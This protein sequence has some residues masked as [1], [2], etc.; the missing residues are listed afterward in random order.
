[1]A[2]K[3]GKTVTAQPKK[4]I[5]PKVEKTAGK[6]SNTEKKAVKEVEGKTSFFSTFLKKKT[7]S[8]YRQKEEKDLNGVEWGVNDLAAERRM[9]K[10]VDN[11]TPT[12]FYITSIFAVFLFTAYVSIYAAIHFENIEYM[13]MM[14]IFLFIVLVSYFLISSIYFIS[15][16]KKWHAVAPMLFFVGITAV[17]V[18]AFKAVDTS[19]LVRYSIVYAIIV[20]GI[21]TYIL[22]IKR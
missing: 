18:Y 10:T 13:N 11:A 12:W 4:N 6:I 3:R 16:K 8:E 22:A 14:I 20:A 7:K 21:S 15:E 19:N 1:M 9:E 17:M 5:A 2:K